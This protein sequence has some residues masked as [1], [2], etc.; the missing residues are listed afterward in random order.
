MHIISWNVQAAKGVDD[1]ID[2]ERIATVLEG[3]GDADVICCQEV[4]V[5]AGTPDMAECDQVGALAARFPAHAPF[6]GSAVDRLDGAGRLRFG[7]LVLSRLPVLQCILHKLP[8][9][10]D[11]S[12]RHMPRQAIEVIV[13][14]RDGPLRIVT[15]HLEYFS[16][17][18]RGAQVRY[19]RNHHADSRARAQRPSPGDGEREFA[20]LP[21]TLRSVYC[22]D[23]NLTVDSDD[24]RALIV[25]DGGAEMID[26]WPLT[27]PG[28]PRAPTCGVFDHVQWTEGPHCRDFFF[29]SSE[30]AGRVSDVAVDVDTAASDHQPIGL[31]LR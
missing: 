27:H 24:Y 11:P 1:V 21:E 9:P 16:T 31:T 15:T 4:L 7:N 26:C 5:A 12:A 29:V 13:E 14:E 30:L 19:L 3:F 20:P 6:F 17:I 23:F 8:Q 28:E 18:Q 2:V 10:V 25:S 22:G